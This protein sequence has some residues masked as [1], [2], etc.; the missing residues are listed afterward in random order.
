M[1][2]DQRPQ[3]RFFQQI[4]VNGKEAPTFSLTRGVYIES[5]NLD[6]PQLVLNLNDLDSNLRDTMKLVSGARLEL[7]MGD[8]TGRGGAYFKSSFV[9][10]SIQPE[11]RNLRV[12]SMEAGIFALKQPTPVP[13]FFIG[14]R[15][16][17]MLADLFPGYT[18]Q[19]TITA[20]VTHHVTAGATP[21]SVLRKLERD[22]G[23]AIW[24]ARGVVYCIPR[25]MLGGQKDGYPMLEYQA[26]KSQHPIQGYKP[27]YEAP[28]A[29]R[30]VRRNYV[31]WDTVGGLLASPVNR[32]SPRK[33]VPG[34]SLDELDGMGA[35]TVP[36][37]ICDMPGNG[38][39]TAGM[40]VGVR[41]HRINREAVL[42][43]S[44]PAKQVIMTV[45]HIDE[46][47]QYRCKLTTGVSQI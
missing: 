25:N 9:V 32:E 7:S 37:L 13:R 18:I 30:E 44:M 45:S 36:A 15:V 5:I 43:E 1:M 21:S 40:T 14:V 6:G 41:L 31:S 26:Q 23:A 33:F 3:Q 24:V 20:K 35:S 27:L 28:T 46:D 17:D 12:E 8:V 19:T 2:S 38:N 10:V 39:Y 16:K 42:D 4:K 11:G 34:A 22:L 47:N 29:A